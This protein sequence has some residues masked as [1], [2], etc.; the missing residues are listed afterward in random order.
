MDSQAYVSDRSAVGEQYVDIEPSGTAGPFLTKGA[1]LTK[2][3][4]VPVATQ[5]LLQNLDQL[6]SHIDTA[7]LNTLVTELGT[8]FN[9]R[10]PDLQALLDSGDRLLARAQQ[11]LPETLKLIDNSQTVLKTQLNSGSAIKDWAHNLA[12]I[13]AQL[14]SSDP[15]LNALLSAG[16][17]ELDAVRQFLSGNRDDLSLLLS[18]LTS[19]NGVLVARLRG[20]ETI[21]LIYPGAIA[22]GFTVTP[23]DGTAHFGLVINNDDPP[24]CI[25]GYQGTVKRQPSD[26][27]STAVNT[28]ARCALPRG[29]KSTV[30]GAQNAP[31]GDPISTT[32]A[33]AAYPRVTPRSAS[34]GPTGA[35]V[36]SMTI[37]GTGGPSAVLAD[38][39]WL[40]LLTG[41]LS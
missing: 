12:L 16:P 19:V 38:N 11:A 4:K 2:P 13:A 3:G 37:G 39:S 17:G 28:G 10:G 35:S 32:G 33:A 27:G 15:D 30:R 18:N 7:K 24:P 20:L 36:S 25:A 29:S 34:P 14:R 23:G 31:G 40:P 8:A 1:V 5:V 9:G 21:L 26:T 6:V 22:G 41:G